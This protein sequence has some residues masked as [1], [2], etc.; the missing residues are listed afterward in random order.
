M[1]DEA[2]EI[3]RVR[4][5]LQAF[6]KDDQDAVRLC[7]DLLYVSHIWDDLYDGD[8]DVNPTDINAAFCK[9]L[10]HIPMNPVYHSSIQVMSVLSLIAALTWRI[11]NKFEKGSEDE[12]IGSFILRNGLLHVIYFVIIMAGAK[13]GEPEW[14]I[15]CGEQFW[16]EF[17]SGYHQ[18]YLDFLKEMEPPNEAHD[19]NL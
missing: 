9:A 3:F 14:G 6:C 18:K 2:A 19:E 11:A 15:T 5:L 16:K 10:G 7:E 13:H 1:S 17:F 12:K 4:Q 8:K